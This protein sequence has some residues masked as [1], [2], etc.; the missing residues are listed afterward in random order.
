MEEREDLE[1]NRGS[2]GIRRPTSLERKC[3]CM[4]RFL[5]LPKYERLT[6]G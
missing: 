3:K 5:R 1:R 2:E 6:D 4:C